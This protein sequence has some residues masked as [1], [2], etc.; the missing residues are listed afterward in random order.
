MKRMR[1]APH[2]L[3][4]CS[5]CQE[6]RGQQGGL[7]TFSHRQH[8]AHANCEHNGTN[9]GRLPWVFLGG[10]FL[11]RGRR[12]SFRLHGRWL[13]RR[14]HLNQLAVPAAD[15]AAG[16]NVALLTCVQCSKQILHEFRGLALGVNVAEKV[17][18]VLRVHRTSLHTSWH[19]GV[20]DNRDAVRSGKDLTRLGQ[21][22]VA[23]A[24]S[25]KVHNDAP[26]AHGRNSILC[27]QQRG[28]SSRNGGR[29]NGNVA[30]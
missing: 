25:C 30:L 9:Q 10:G 27:N 15:D 4:S 3:I 23:T 18:H 2:S 14:R 28:G 21:L 6:E 26:W 24:R 16:D 20:A 7:N 13:R 22:A 29:A 5:T 1:D 12:S 19:V 8:A 17:A 11:V